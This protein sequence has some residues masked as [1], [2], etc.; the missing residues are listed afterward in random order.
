MTPN[1]ANRPTSSRT[2]ARR[3]DDPALLLL[4]RR[5]DSARS[6]SG[7]AVIAA[8]AEGTKFI[9]TKSDSSKEDNLDNLPTF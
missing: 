5:F 8:S 7:S 4:Q 9:K 2:P 1:P 3:S 6:A